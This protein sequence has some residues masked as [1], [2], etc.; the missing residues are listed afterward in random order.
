QK[1]LVRACLRVVTAVRAVVLRL[2]NLDVRRYAEA[3]DRAAGR[4]VVARRGDT[5]GTVILQRQGRLDRSLSIGPGA[6]EGR[7]VVILEG[8]GDDLG[9]RRR[10]AVDQNDHGETVGKV[11]GLRVELPVASR[12]SPLCR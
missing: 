4:R 8:G 5:D 11:T 2:R 7:P 12:T 9:G 3:V 6:Q 1:L 10:S